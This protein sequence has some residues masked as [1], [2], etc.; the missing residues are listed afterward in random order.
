MWQQTF[1]ATLFLWEECSRLVSPHVVIV[2]NVTATLNDDFQC[3]F[4]D[5]II[6]KGWKANNVQY[7]K[8]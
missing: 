1:T 8:R 6:T 7:Y 5:N 3:V 4:T 2:R